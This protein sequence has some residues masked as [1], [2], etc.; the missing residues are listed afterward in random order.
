MAKQQSRDVGG[1]W[2]AMGNDVR[3]KGLG[4]VSVVIEAAKDAFWE[5]R[6]RKGG[7]WWRLCMA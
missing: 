2:D 7:G 3:I 5:V 6:R 1:A 4:G